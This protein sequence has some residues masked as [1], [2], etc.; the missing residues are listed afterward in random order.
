MHHATVD[1]YEHRVDAWIKQR[2]R[3]VPPQ[4]AEFV[5]KIGA[6]PR[7]DLGCGPGW[8][9]A[10]LG[11]P[12]VA[13]DAALAMVQRV[14]Q[15]APGALPIRGDLERLPFRAGALSGAWAHKCYMHLPGV[16][17]PLALAE[18]HRAVAL[19]G[20]GAHPSDVRPTPT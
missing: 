4:L 17:L 19:G 3:A 13:L 6:G 8:H 5:S 15:F 12:V 2:K 11:A 1:V 9:C 14:P 16:N 20:A 7:A 18:L 10:H